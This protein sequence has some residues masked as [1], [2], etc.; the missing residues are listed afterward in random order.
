MVPF[1][2]GLEINDGH[3]AQFTCNALPATPGSLQ[4]TDCVWL[5]LWVELTVTRKWPITAVSS[6][7]TPRSKRRWGACRFRR[8]PV[9]C[10]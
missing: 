3:F 5:Q 4:N 10:R 9:C 1:Q 2:T 7:T 8:T 6:P